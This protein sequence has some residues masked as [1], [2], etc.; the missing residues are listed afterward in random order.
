MKEKKKP[1]IFIAPS[2]QKALTEE[3]L[4][5]I[6][7]CTSDAWFWEEF[8]HDEEKKHP[9]EDALKPYIRTKKEGEDE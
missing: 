1:C 3:E 7:E 6:E 9:L 5:T 4:A 2:D 8:L